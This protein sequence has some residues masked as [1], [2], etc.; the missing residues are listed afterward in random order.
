MRNASRGGL[1]AYSLED[2]ELGEE[3]AAGA[4]CKVMR[5]SIQLDGTTVPLA[6]KSFLWNEHAAE[7][8]DGLSE[9]GSGGHDDGH[10]LRETSADAM[11]IAL[12][13]RA[14][15]ARANPVWLADSATCMLGSNCQNVA[16]S[17]MVKPHHC[18]YCGWVV[19]SDCR[20]REL[21]V[22]RWVSS[23]THEIKALV[24]PATKAKAV[25]DSCFLHAPQEVRAR[26]ERN[27]RTDDYANVR[28]KMRAEAEILHR[29]VHRNVVGVLGVCDI[30]PSLCLLLEWCPRGSLYDVLRKEREAHSSESGTEAGSPRS[31]TRLD[32][33]RMG[34]AMDVV[35]ALAHL[36]GPLGGSSGPRGWAV[37]HRDVKSHNYLVAVDGTVKL[38]D[39]GDAQLESNSTSSVAGLLS[40]ASSGDGA[41]SPS[42]VMAAGAYS[43]HQDSATTSKPLEFVRASCSVNRKASNPCYTRSAARTSARFVG[44]A[45]MSITAAV[46]REAA[47]LAETTG[48]TGL[49][50]II[51]KSAAKLS[52]NMEAES[53]IDSV[54]AG[55][56]EWMAPELLA[57][58]VPPTWFEP[59]T[60][61][62]TYVVDR[63]V[64][65][66]REAVSLLLQG[67]IRSSRLFCSWS[68]RSCSGFSWS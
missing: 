49:G 61:K 40:G 21:E 24:P 11:A 41:M 63:Q 65:G 3:I 62:G 16:F 4:S 59:D 17:L 44:S 50:G 54:T 23:D 68:S 19:C 67:A 32:A 64:P 7:D 47:S 42:D 35:R 52:L 8:G 26:A 18:R 2:F 57:T 22:D 37:A 33:T 6:V 29:C 30:H 51:A 9:H 25:C 46:H 15:E 55:T 60:E 27:Q 10:G 1:N 45:V 53:E 43:W 48:A 5:G 28:R 12:E 66:L 38:A 20:R 13:A 36:H 58:T 14:A 31:F 56:P 39:L 34:Y